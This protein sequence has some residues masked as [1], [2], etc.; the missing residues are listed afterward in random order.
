M[1]NKMKCKQNK[2]PYNCFS[3]NNMQT[4]EFSL[5]HYEIAMYCTFKFTL[6]FKKVIFLEFNCKSNMNTEY[7]SA[8][9]NV[10]N[11]VILC[12]IEIE[13]FKIKIHSMF[14]YVLCLE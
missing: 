11:F 13:P 7:S 10:N 3:S 8:R 5:S 2:P 14:V 12:K 4:K 1:N 6:L 9:T